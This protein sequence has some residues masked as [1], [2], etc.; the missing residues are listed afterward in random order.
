MTSDLSITD[1]RAAL[2]RIRPLVRHTPLL[3][4]PFLDEIA[5]R[6]LFVKP[7]CLQHTGSFK[8]RGACSAMTQLAARGVEG[9]VIAYSSGNHAQAVALAAQRAGREAVI[10]MP[11]DAPQ[12]KI[13]NTR[14]YGAEVVLYDRATQRR[15][16]IAAQIQ[17]TRTLTL[18][19]PFDDYDV[20]AGQGTTGLEITADLKA[21]GIE[22]AD[23]LVCT[24]GGGLCS[25]IAT[26]MKAEMPQAR[27]FA[28]EPEGY[29]DVARSLAS[30]TRETNAQTSGGLWD[31]VIT[32][33]PGT[34]TF[35]IM[36]RLVDGALVVSE[37][38]TWSAMTHAFDRLK[39]VA[40]PGG[41]IALAAA[42]SHKIT[43]RNT[44]MVALIS[45]GNVD[46]AVFEK[47]MTY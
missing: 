37:P 2:D 43:D 10:I 29:D 24:G 22:A 18:I 38:E 39:L 7:E 1:I 36:Q 21:Q 25:G 16:D 15:E 30:G 32:P 9:G 26:A 11:S 5:G 28:V 45:G 46:R 23:I 4:S 17:A 3:S 41:A 34:L 14:A 40:E 12:I 8:F 13:D 35:P 47:V 33:S 19:P 20:M 6:P 27:V 31:A 42:L 44:P